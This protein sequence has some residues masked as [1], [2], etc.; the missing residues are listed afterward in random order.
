MPSLRDIRQQGSQRWAEHGRS[1]AV[2][3]ACL[4]LDLGEADHQ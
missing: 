1:V 2:L 3:I 4:Y